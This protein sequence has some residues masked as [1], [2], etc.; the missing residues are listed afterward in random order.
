MKTHMCREAHVRFC[1][2]GISVSLE[3]TGEKDEYR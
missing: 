2:G 1:C 3:K